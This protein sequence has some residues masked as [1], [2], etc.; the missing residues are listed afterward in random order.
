MR[1]MR[2]REVRDKDMEFTMTDKE[3]QHNQHDYADIYAHDFFL[4]RDP[5]SI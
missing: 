5:G 1:K 4:G 2:K 3:N